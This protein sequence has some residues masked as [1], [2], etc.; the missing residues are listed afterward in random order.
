MVLL[1][2][3]NQASGTLGASTGLQGEVLRL[4][5]SIWIWI[6]ILLSNGHT[7]G[8]LDEMGCIGTTRLGEHIMAIRLLSTFL[9]IPPNSALFKAIKCT[10]GLIST[11]TALWKGK[12]CDMGCLLRSTS[13]SIGGI[14]APHRELTMELMNTCG[15]SAELTVTFVI[16]RICGLLECKGIDFPTQAIEC[17]LDMLGKHMIPSSPLYAALISSRGI[18]SAIIRFLE[19]VANN[20]D[21]IL[22]EC[23][24]VAVQDPD[25]VCQFMGDFTLAGVIFCRQFEMIG[26]LCRAQFAYHHVEEL[27]NSPFMLLLYHADA[28]SVKHPFYVNFCAA[29]SSLLT[30]ILPRFS[31]YRNLLRR[32]T[33]VA[34]RMRSAPSEDSETNK[35]PKALDLIRTR[36]QQYSEYKTDP[37]A[38]LA[39]NNLEVRIQAKLRYFI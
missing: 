19:G 13:H 37:C 22:Q 25:G 11:L 23:E 14:F 35:M 32:M 28:P 1:L 27:L 20:H 3:I 33:N 36:I 15:G 38:V 5:P 8:S 10:P 34:S 9:E 12:D 4:W 24:K 17:D 39:C 29:R 18:V 7:C 2:G 21:I 16:K 30:E 6:Q 31:V 26:D